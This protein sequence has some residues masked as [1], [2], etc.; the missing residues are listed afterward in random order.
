MRGEPIRPRTSTARLPAAVEYVTSGD[1]ALVSVTG[2]VDERF[3]GFGDVG[4]MKTVVINVAGLLHDV[5]GVG[6]C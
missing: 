3:A 4:A 1:A 2:L 6:S 5:F